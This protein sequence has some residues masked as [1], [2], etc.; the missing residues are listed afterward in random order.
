MNNVELELVEPERASEPEADTTD[1]QSYR[2]S[3][4][5]WSE[6]DFRLYCSSIEKIGPAEGFDLVLIDGRARPSCLMHAVRRVKPCG[7]ILLDN[8]D[9]ETY[10]SA[11]ESL[12]RDFTRKDFPGATPYVPFFTRT[13]AFRAPPETEVD[14]ESE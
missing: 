12:T 13:S 7:T 1:P 6:W 14:Q 3:S 5:D 11:I 10:A 4:T 9:R 2:S 8:S